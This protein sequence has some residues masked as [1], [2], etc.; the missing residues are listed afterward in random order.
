MD[1]VATPTKW[2][3]LPS[4][5]VPTMTEA[6]D[7]CELPTVYAR[8]EPDDEYPKPEPMDPYLIDEDQEEIIEEEEVDED[9]L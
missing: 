2:I 9:D 4:P 1:G 7:F 8:A 3:K 5:E 6:R